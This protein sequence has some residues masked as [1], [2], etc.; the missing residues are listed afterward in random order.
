MI[1]AVHPRGGRTKGNNMNKITKVATP[2]LIAI[3]A[4]LLFSRLPISADTFAGIFT[5]IFVL[6]VMALEYGIT[7]KRLFGR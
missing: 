1:A 2:A 5:G 4:F 7:W 6:A 3:A